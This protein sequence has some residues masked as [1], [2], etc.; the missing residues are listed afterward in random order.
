MALTD[1]DILITPNKGQTA[2][3]KIEFKGASSTVGAQT[4]S[5]NVYP[6]DNG[7]ISFEG[8]AGQLFSITN[9][10][11]GTIYSV[12]DVSGIPSIE[13]LDTGLIKLGQYNGNILLGT[14]TD[15]GLDKLQVN[16]SIALSNKTR[17]SSITYTTT[18]T[19]Q[20]A[21]DTF[22][23][24]TYRTAKYTVQLSSGS[25]YQSSDILV[26]HNGTTA[27]LSQ[28]GLVNTSSDLGSFDCSLSS[29][30][31][32]LLL[33]PVNASTTVVMHRILINV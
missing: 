26:V 9:S 7:T 10:L 1:K 23:S 19:S 20:V 30:T 16:G 13:V 33:T 25:S 4:I 5:L 6:T 17:M 28:Y 14:A 22:P 31:V 32:S 21:I 12:N 3:P 11:S 29:G 27:Y 8:T 24:A 18:T 15:N 2:E